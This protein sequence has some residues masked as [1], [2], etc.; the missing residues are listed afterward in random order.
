MCVMLLKLC[1]F[2]FLTWIGLKEE[3]LKLDDF[4]P[5]LM[6]FVFNQRA[7]NAVWVSFDL[8][9]CEQPFKLSLL[10]NKI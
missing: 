6:E 1:F 3:M 8:L 10:D 2:F 9:N 7:N 5:P 4:F